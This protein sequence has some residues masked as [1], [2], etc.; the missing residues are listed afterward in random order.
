MNGWTKNAVGLA[1]ASTAPPV[2]IPLKNQHA[3]LLW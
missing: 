3:V 2:Q 1:D